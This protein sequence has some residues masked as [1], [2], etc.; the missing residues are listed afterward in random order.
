M[1]TLRDYQQE[2]VDSVLHYFMEGNKGNPVVATP[3][4]T[5]KSLILA[6]MITQFMCMFPGQRF[7]AATHVK[8][9]IVQDYNKLVQYWPEAPVGIYSAG[10]KQKDV[11]CDVIIGGIQSLVKVA[12]AFGW[13]DILFID[14]AHLLSPNDASMYQVFIAILR[15][16]NPNLKVVGLTASPYRMGQGMITDGGLFTDI[17]IDLTGLEPFNRF[18]EEGF[19]APLVARPTDIKLDTTGIHINNGDFVQ[20]ELERA[21]DDQHILE[22]ALRETLGWFLQEK[23]KCGL[24]FLNSN[25]HVIEAAELLNSM[26]MPTVP[27]YNG[28]KGKERDNNINAW[29][30][31]EVQFATSQNML[32]T[33]VDCPQL[34]LIADLAATVSTGRHVQ[35]YGRGTRPFDWYKLS[36]DEQCRMPNL[37]GHVKV[38]ARCLDFAGNVPRL[39]PINDPVI[40]KRKGD[41]GGVAPIKICETE[42]LVQPIGEA[43]VVGCGAYNHAS[44][45][46]CDECGGEFRIQPKVYDTA[47]TDEIIR[48]AREVEPSTAPQIETFNVDNVFYS[49]QEVKGGKAMLKATY[50]CGLRSFT[51]LKGFEHG[52]YAGKLARDW[53]R[54]R[55]SSEPPTTIDYAL[56]LNAQL[57]KPKTIDVN[58][59]P[60]YPEIVSYGW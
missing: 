33:G 41:K 28:L 11:A 40:P 47:G 6:G 2:C 18:I 30:F 27:V 39:G 32:T 60:K 8:E 16:I 34:D 7:I 51:E 48:S 22:P 56:L 36:Q 45:R 20:G 29:R 3:C 37:M 35:K 44:A 10:L 17:C 38:N 53:W 13:R 25:K 55:A 50:Q 23:R 59:I 31:G 57:A 58:V 1:L 49:R 54:Q 21:M 19:L 9:L 12:H 15:E 26:G 46:Y 52:G 5:G 43:A 24:V 4:G 42:K 14:E